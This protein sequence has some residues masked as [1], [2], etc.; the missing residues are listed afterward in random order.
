MYALE[1]AAIFALGCAVGQGLLGRCY[2][3]ILGRVMATRWG[4][5]R[6]TNRAVEGYAALFTPEGTEALQRFVREFSEDFSAALE[7]AGL[8]RRHTVD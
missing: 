3:M 6:M 2:R 7:A 8:S 1:L 4:R 5:R